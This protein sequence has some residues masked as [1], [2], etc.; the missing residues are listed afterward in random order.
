MENR[1]NFLLWFGS[2]L[3]TPV[4]TTLTYSFGSVLKKKHGTFSFRDHLSAFL[5]SYVIPSS[6]KGKGKVFFFFSL[7]PLL[8]LLIVFS[9]FK[10]PNR[11]LLIQQSRNLN[12]VSEAW[13]E[14]PTLKL[15]YFFSPGSFPHSPIN[16]QSSTQGRKKNGVWT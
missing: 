5:C 3:L 7:P 12:Y 10:T 16:C 8:A 1:D 9:G 6:R 14:I 15:F 11:Y 13:L 2:G 4:S